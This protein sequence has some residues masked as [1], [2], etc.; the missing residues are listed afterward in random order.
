MKRLFFTH[1]E[2]TRTDAELDAIYAELLTNNQQ[3]NCE[4]IIAQEGVEVVL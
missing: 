3:M 4:L 1:H 2:P